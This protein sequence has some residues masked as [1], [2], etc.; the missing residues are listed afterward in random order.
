MWLN[1]PSS[2]KHELLTRRAAKGCGE[3]SKPQR[4]T[5]RGRLTSGISDSFAVFV[6]AFS[7]GKRIV[8]GSKADRCQ[9]SAATGLGHR[10]EQLHVRCA[11]RR[12]SS[13]RAPPRRLV[14]AHPSR[15]AAQRP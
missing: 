5:Y 15:L 3:P 1:L 9:R 10:I 14:R 7:P 11:Q 12:G 8:A 13:G 2:T 6:A 4:F